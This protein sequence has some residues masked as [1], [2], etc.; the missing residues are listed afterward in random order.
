MP[1]T[2]DNPLYYFIKLIESDTLKTQ[3][4]KALNDF[5]D[6]VGG[7][8]K[9]IDYDKGIIE[10][11]QFDNFNSIDDKKM[12]LGTYSFKESFPKIIDK[13][14][15]LAKKKIDDIVL[16][17]NKNGN[18]ANQFLITQ[19]KHLNILAEK[20]KFVYPKLKFIESALESIISYLVDR[21][22]LRESY[23]KRSSDFPTKFSFFDIKP[24]IKSVLVESLYD[25]SVDLEIIDDEIVS[26]ETFINV[27]TGNPTA[28]DEAIIFKCNNELAAHFINCI[29]PLFNN[30]S[31]AQI[32]KSKS[33]I[34][35]NMKVLNQADLD[36][37]NKRLR[38]KTSPKLER[39]T[40]HI[41][42]MLD[43]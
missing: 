2:K 24:S 31:V 38:K 1:E 29:Q 41:T 43:S 28:S 39:I 25:S 30:L 33:F 32:D 4:D 40:Y 27:L 36:N 11:W 42:R 34:N 35:K 17:I 8:F 12:D 15:K 7:Y 3:R 19:L 5:K 6:Y 21:Y 9:S 26:E 14:S 37:A 10:Y 18:N 20:S 13:E 16:E 22:S 23:K